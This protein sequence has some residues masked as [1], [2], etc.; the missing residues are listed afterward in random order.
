MQTKILM[1]AAAWIAATVAPAMAGTFTLVET[2]TV[3]G[4]MNGVPFTNAGITITM[5][6]DT[7]NFAFVGGSNPA[8]KNGGGYIDVEGF[9]R[10]TLPAWDSFNVVNIGGTVYLVDN[11]F[12]GLGFSSPAVAGWD[13]K[14]PIG[15]VTGTGSALGGYPLSSG[16]LSITGTSG[17][18]TLTSSAPEPASMALVGAMLIIGSRAVRRR[19]TRR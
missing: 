14:T 1:T 6:G 2:G 3:S 12:Q 13:T 17:T 15:P 9:S 7:A 18:F 4:K 10:V 16:S 11:G 19:P 8:V 5:F